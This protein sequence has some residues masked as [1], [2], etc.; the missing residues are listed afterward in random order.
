MSGLPQIN[1]LG[2]LDAEGKRLN[3][4]REWP[5]PNTDLSYREYFQTLKDDP[6]I[7]SALGR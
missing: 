5:S 2:I 6:K 3:N 4:S 1:T 7:T